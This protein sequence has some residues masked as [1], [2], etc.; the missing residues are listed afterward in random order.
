M[1][2]EDKNRVKGTNCKLAST[3]KIK[4]MK[5]FNTLILLVIFNLTVFGTAQSPDKLL[6]NGKE[7]KLHTNPMESYFEKYPEKRPKSK[8]WSSALERG[9]V[10]TFEIIDNQLYLKDIEIQTFKPFKRH[11]FEY[12]WK[13]V[14]NKVFPNQKLIKIDWVTGL[15]IIPYGEIVDYVHLE[16]G[17]IYEHY[18]ILEIEN[19]SLKKEK[20]LEYQEFVEFREKQFQI[21][22]ETEEYKKSKQ[23]LKEMTEWDD[24]FIDYVLQSY[25]S[26][27]IKNI[28]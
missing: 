21:Y 1:E 10:A 16:Y 26:T 17:S 5:I 2:C 25:I 18:I 22:K 20:Q 7:Y 14:K 3:E 9:Y 24:E 8:M 6:Y 23:E 28:D 11:R 15:L 4:Y 19:G 12:E 13:S 27:Y